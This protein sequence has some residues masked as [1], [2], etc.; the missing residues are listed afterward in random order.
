M[1]LLLCMYVFFRVCLVLVAFLRNFLTL[2][3]SLFAIPAYIYYYVSYHFWIC[4]LLSSFFLIIRTYWPISPSFSPHSLHYFHIL[5]IQSTYVFMWMCIWYDAVYF[6]FNFFIRF[7]LLCV[8]VSALALDFPLPLYLFTKHT[9]LYSVCALLLLL[10]LFFSFILS[11]ISPSLKSFA[12]RCRVALLWNE[13][14]KMC[15][16]VQWI[17]AGIDVCMWNEY[18]LP[19]D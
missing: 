12:V 2:F 1:L 18:S 15:A 5:S 9:R 6:F 11:S 8:C 16:F 7:R 13:H 14:T 4:L 19:L 17:A 10:S 3:A